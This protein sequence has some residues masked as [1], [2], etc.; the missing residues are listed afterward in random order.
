MADLFSVEIP[1][2]H[3]INIRNLALSLGFPS[4]SIVF[5]IDNCS[6]GSMCVSIKSES[7]ENLDKFL[8]DMVQL[9][10]IYWRVITTS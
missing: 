10:H 4:E 2:E 8:N 5:R 6:F 3:C 1:Q 7:V 9:F